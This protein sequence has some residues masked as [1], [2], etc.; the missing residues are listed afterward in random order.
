[1]LSRVAY[2]IYWAARYLERAENVARF[3]AVNQDLSLEAQADESLQWSPL[4]NT[5]GDQDL[6]AD[7]HGAITRDQ[8]IRFLAFDRRYANSIISSLWLA[9]ENARSV[10]NILSRDMWLRINA[11]YLEVQALTKTRDTEDSAVVAFSELVKLGC[12]TVQGVTDATMSRTEAWH[13]WRIGSLLE[14]ADKTSRILDVKY[15]MLLPSPQDIGTNIDHAQWIALLDSASAAQMFRQSGR[16]LKPTEIAGFLIL[17]QTFPRAIA[18]SIAEADNSLHAI[19]GTPAGQ[20]TNEAE[21]SLGR[22]RA[23]LCYADIE[24]IIDDGLHEY[25]DDRQQ[26]LNDIDRLLAAHYFGDS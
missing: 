11:L 4:I 5:T 23:E 20:F 16:A 26:A 8:A 2:N 19:T 18:H 7:R 3:L 25:L 22:L 6:Y 1:M 21:R 15:F 14:R 13:W 12:I 10:R 9:R 24:R 17:D